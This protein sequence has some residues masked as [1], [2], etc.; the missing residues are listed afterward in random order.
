MT[1]KYNYVYKLTFKE[2]PRYYYIGKHSTDNIGDNYM[3]SGR[4]LRKY[5][6]TYGKNCFSKEILFMYSTEE[7]ALQKESELVTESEIHDVFCLNRCLGGGSNVTAGTVVVR[8]SEGNVFR[9]SIWDPKYLDKTYQSVCR[10][11]IPSKE[12][13][14]LWSTQRKGRSPWNKG[15][16]MSEETKQKLSKINTGKKLSSSTCKKLAENTKGRKAIFKGDMR[17]RVKSEELQGYLDEGW[18]LGQGLKMRK[19]NKDGIEKY[20]RE[21]T[22][23]KW[24]Q[25]G[26]SKGSLP[27]SEE[28]K[29]TLS[30]NM[31]VR[32]SN[33]DYR[34]KLSKIQKELWKN[35]EYRKKHLK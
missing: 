34:Q 24:L 16:S 1:R 8:D 26:W 7:E 25:E 4:G 28:F 5:R 22:L 6:E 11:R 27:K 19:I 13:R 10:G 23:Y 12:T 31:K 32:W 33:E 20:V 17:K 9:C 14:K 29:K 35:P 18:I 15:K 21:N 30:K 2:D 3:G